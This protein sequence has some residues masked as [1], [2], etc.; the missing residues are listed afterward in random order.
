MNTLAQTDVARETYWGITSVEYAVFYF[1]AFVTVAV[2]TYGVYQRFARYTH[3]DGEPFPRLDELQRR[4]ANAAKI[5]AA[6]ANRT[7]APRAFPES[8]ACRSRTISAITVSSTT[9]CAA[10][11]RSAS[12]SRS[13]G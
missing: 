8:V 2:F 10:M 6:T 5:V 1:L 12:G 11:R 13:S 4:V 7:A 3:G 9:P